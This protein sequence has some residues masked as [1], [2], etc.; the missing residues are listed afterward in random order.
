MPLTRE[1]SLAWYKEMFD[2]QRGRGGREGGMRVDS[3]LTVFQIR[4]PHLAGRSCS[5]YTEF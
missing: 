3:L 5:F 1:M 4:M 2:G